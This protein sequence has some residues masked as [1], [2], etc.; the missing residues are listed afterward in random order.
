MTIKILYCG[1]YH[2]DLHHA[3]NDW[4]I[5]MYPVVPR[6]ADLDGFQTQPL[7]HFLLKQHGLCVWNLGFGSGKFEA[8][9][10]EEEGRRRNEQC[11]T[12]RNGVGSV[13]SGG[14]PGSHGK[15][16]PETIRK[17]TFWSCTCC[18]HFLGLSSTP[19]TGRN[20][21]SRLSLCSKTASMGAL[22]HSFS[23]ASLTPTAL[24]LAISSSEAHSQSQKLSS[25]L[26][27]FIFYS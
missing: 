4:G 5:T 21:I 13:G 22:I 11:K 19:S 7:R 10:L 16:R 8:L 25:S 12:V 1:I 3:K 24:Q 17:V 6:L 9:E 20:Q 2:I 27:A 18:E 14:A 23:V 26:E 15:S